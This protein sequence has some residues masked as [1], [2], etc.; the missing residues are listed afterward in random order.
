MFCFVERTITCEA[1]ARNTVRGPDHSFAA[2]VPDQVDLF[3]S[4]FGGDRQAE[5]EPVRALKC[6]EARRYTYGHF[7]C[8]RH[9][10]YRKF[11]SALFESSQ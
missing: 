9:R 7:I 6:V 5:F 4:P 8:P 2:R 1:L 3:A 10:E 11:M